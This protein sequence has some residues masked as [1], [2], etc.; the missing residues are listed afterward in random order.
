MVDNGCLSNSQKELASKVK[1]VIL[2]MSSMPKNMNFKDCAE[3]L[4]Y[5]GFTKMEIDSEF[6]RFS[7]MYDEYSK[8]RE[9]GLREL[10]D[11]EREKS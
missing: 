8:L 4:T 9:A 11:H 6:D 10:S 5:E 3:I 1:A 7:R 2:E